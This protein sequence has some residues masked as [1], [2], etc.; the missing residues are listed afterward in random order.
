M[1]REDSHPGLH[2]T[3]IF[4]SF[5]MQ[6]KQDSLSTP[7]KSPCLSFLHS[8]RYPSN[9]VVKQPKKARSFILLLTYFI[10]LFVAVLDLRCYTGFL[11]L[12]QTGILFIAVFW[13]LITAASLVSKYRLQGV[14][15]SVLWY[16]GLVIWQHVEFSKS[17]DQTCV[18]CLD[19]Q[20]LVH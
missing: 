8:L 15:F 1:Y 7:K 2:L 14:K 17:R 9:S 4:C 19:R 5:R 18:P 16:T 12:Q 11:Q 13:P 3:E 20:I 6:R 10:F